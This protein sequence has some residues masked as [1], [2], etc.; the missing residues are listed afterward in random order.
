MHL[1]QILGTERWIGRIQFLFCGSYSLVARTDQK[2]NNY[3]KTRKEMLV[4]GSGGKCMGCFKELQPWVLKWGVQTAR[5]TIHR[6][7]GVRRYEKEWRGASKKT[8]SQLCS[9]TQ[10]S[11]ISPSLC[12]AQ[13]RLPGVTGHRSQITG[14]IGCFEH[15]V[16][17]SDSLS[18]KSV[19]PE[20]QLSSVS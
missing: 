16:S 12:V 4:A 14:P 13:R 11:G 18:M 1:C 20:C 15:V 7:K 6:E 8:I 3:K 17:V 9:F 19:P 5:R 10:A 2:S